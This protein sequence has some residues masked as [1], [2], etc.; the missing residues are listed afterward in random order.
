MKRS[1][2]AAFQAPTPKPTIPGIC[3]WLVTRYRSRAPDS[4]VSSNV[5][6]RNSLRASESALRH[7]IPRLESIRADQQHPEVHPGRNARTPRLPG[8]RTLRLQTQ[9]NTAKLVTMGCLL[10]ITVALVA[11][12]AAASPVDAQD[13]AEIAARADARGAPVNLSASITLTITSPNGDQR[14]IRADSYQKQRG[15]ERQDRLFV[16]TFPPNVRDTALLVHSNTEQGEDSMWMYLPA[17]DRIKRVDLGS[18][19]GGYFLGSDFTFRDLV[20]RAQ[21]E[22]VRALLPADGDAHFVVEVRGRTPELQRTFGYSREEHFIRKDNF[23]RE[24]IVFYDLAGDL[25]K[26]LI[27][28]EE[29][30]ADGYA[31]PSRVRMLNHQTGH[32]S[33]IL[34]ED[35]SFSAEIPDRYFT[36]RY[37]RRR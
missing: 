17:M 13:A 1:R 30:A 11:G 10:L 12:L 5:I 16:F 6:A 29:H 25:L 33:E 9:G 7:A 31:F 2:G 4:G 18:S 21:S 27:V 26:E 19:G 32:V 23:T 8:R 28:Q 14:V 35:I 3:R 15:A 34:F 20:S 36:Q 22:Y 24:R 37:L